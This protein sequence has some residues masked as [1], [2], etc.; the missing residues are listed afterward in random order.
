[1]GNRNRCRYRVGLDHRR[2]RGLVLFV[3]WQWLLGRRGGEPLLPLAL[4]KDRNFSLGNTTIMVVGFT[5]TAFP[6]PT[7]FYYRV[8][9]GLTPPNQ[10]C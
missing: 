1:M 2:A 3:L 4:F 9:R 5:V 10:P 7:I 8:V 6:L